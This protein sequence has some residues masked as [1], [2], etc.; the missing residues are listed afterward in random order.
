MEIEF[1]REAVSTL[2]PENILPGQFWGQVRGRV[3]FSKS[4]EYR[5]AF[6]ELE[7]AISDW[8]LAPVEEL[9]EMALHHGPDFVY[10][11][12]YNRKLRALDAHLWIF[13]TGARGV[14]SFNGVCEVLNL[15]PD[16]MRAGLLE[17]RTYWKHYRQVR[18]SLR[19]F[20]DAEEG[21]E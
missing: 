5:L 9:N 3:L 14:F 16:C 6:A 11:G 2:E 21:K 18:R 1:E 8:C 10:T 4:G 19:G 20:G 15:E 17:A 12:G 13:D 7:E